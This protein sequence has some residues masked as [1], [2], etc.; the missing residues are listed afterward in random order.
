MGVAPGVGQQAVQYWISQI[1][2]RPGTD[3]LL[4]IT[5]AEN[6]QTGLDIIGGMAKYLTEEDEEKRDKNLDSVIYDVSNFLPKATGVP[7]SLAKIIR[8][9][10]TVDADDLEQ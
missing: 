8:E 5:A 1:D 10:L 7:S 6:I 4:Q 3:P 2:D 9:Q